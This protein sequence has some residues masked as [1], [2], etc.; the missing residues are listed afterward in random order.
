MGYFRSERFPPMKRTRYQLELRAPCSE[1]WETMPPVPHG[2]FCQSCAKQVVDFTGLTDDQV[3]FLLKKSGGT[4]CG[5]V[6]ETQLDRDLVSRSET[7]VSARLFKIFAGFFLL[8]STKSLAQQ[9][10]VKQPRALT[11]AP[12]EQE[13]FEAKKRHDPDYTLQTWV[14]GRVISA[15]TKVPVEGAWVMINGMGYAAVSDSSGLF[16]ILLPD[17]LA[18]QS[19][20]LHTLHPNYGSKRITVRADEFP[21]T[22][23]LPPPSRKVTISTGGLAVVKRKWW[24]RKRC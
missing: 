9:P 14:K 11:H 18:N 17:S 22:L 8:A 24:Q 4:L 23:E 16:R 3:L 12:T 13:L 7:S 6:A 20:R 5:R 1:S 15:E 21:D 19:N 10:I 2:R